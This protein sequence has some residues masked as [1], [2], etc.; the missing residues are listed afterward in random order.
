[1]VFYTLTA[2]VFVAELIILCFFAVSL[3]KTNRSIIDANK[4]LNEA[5]PKITELMKLGTQISE[6]LTELAPMAEDKVKEKLWELG[7]KHFK[8]VL[9]TTLLWAAKKKYNLKILPWIGTLFR[10]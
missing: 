7:I 3:V 10:V 9:I 5:N 1:M 2:V 8:G 4:F 6:Q